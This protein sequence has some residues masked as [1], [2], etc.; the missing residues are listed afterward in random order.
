MKNKPELL[1]PAGSP[2][3]FAAAFKAGADAFYMGAGDFNARKRARNFSRDELKDATLFAHR[4][5][6]RVYITLNTLVFDDEFPGVIDLL[7][8]LEEI[9]IDGVILQDL[10]L[11][12]MLGKHFPDI[13]AHAST[14]LFCHNSQQALYLKNAGVRRIILA[15]ELSLDEI[16]AIAAAVPLEYEVFVHGA[17]CFSF[18]GCCL[19]SSYLHGDSGNR[20]RCRQPCRTPFDAGRGAE[21]PFSM[22]DLSAASLVSELVASGVSAFKI[23]GR[24]RNAAYVSRTVALYRALIDGAASTGGTRGRMGKRAA[25]GQREAEG[26]YLRGRDYGR[27]VGAERAGS[28]GELIGEVVSIKG[29]QLVFASES[30]LAKGSRL[31]V[32]DGEGKM[33]HEGTL[34]DYARPGAGLY[35]WKLT[36]RVPRAGRMLVHHTGESR[37]F[38]DWPAIRREAGLH[39]YIPL[40]LEITLYALECTVV[41]RFDDFERMQFSWPI[42]SEPART[43][44]LSEAMLREIFTR[45]DRYPFMIEE[46][47]VRLAPGIFVHIG[48][49]KAVR[50]DF[51]KRMYERWE[52]LRVHR[53]AARKTAILNEIETIRDA[54]STDERLYLEYAD[55]ERGERADF[56][57]IEFESIDAAAPPRPDEVILLPLFVSEGGLP[58]ICKTIDGLVSRG[59][60]RFMIPTYG[61]IEYFKRFDGIELFGGPFLYMVNSLAYAAITGNGVRYFTVSPDMHNER[62][63]TLSYRGRLVPRTFRREFM[64]TRLRLPEDCYRGAKALLRVA[65]HAEYDIVYEAD[66]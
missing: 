47:R 18:S 2:E 40:R 61:W 57:V 44:A 31:R 20:G 58:A 22:K 37:A 4:N 56:R 7:S 15:R 28:S 21:Y 11:L 29:S 50:R 14:Q 33:L 6:R 9:R 59:C 34:L 16:G 54:S 63:A 43:E 36:K 42:D 26:G 23:E 39:K 66:K 49:L 12:S 52:A 25:P 62:I 48:A 8:F 65:H 5:G 53:D 19:F 38:R 51:F 41:A 13:P 10:G 46:C 35:E 1:A 45:T 17:M 30:E 32:V 60:R 64:A 24:L 3:T 27:L 55:M